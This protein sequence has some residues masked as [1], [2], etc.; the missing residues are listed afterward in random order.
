MVAISLLLCAWC[1]TS[2]QHTN[3]AH[4]AASRSAPP[5]PAFESSPL[6]GDALLAMLLELFRPEA[7]ISA[8]GLWV[9]PPTSGL[10]SNFMITAAAVAVTAMSVCALQQLWFEP[11]CQLK[12]RCFLNKQ[13]ITHIQAC[14]HMVSHSSAM[15]R[16]TAL[17]AAM[18]C[19][20]HQVML[21]VKICHATI[22]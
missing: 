7:H 17:S 3:A 11:W 6:H 20:W 21:V 15:C 22:I 9:Q 12:L 2:P 19:A 1:G 4:A 5:V 8:T 18:L 13:I 14:K 10:R 16:V